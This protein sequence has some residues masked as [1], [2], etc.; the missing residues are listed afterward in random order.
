MDAAC[1]VPAVA[2][3]P[4]EPADIR[5]G[6]GRAPRG[7][8]GREPVDPDRRETPCS[9]CWASA[10]A[11]AV[12]AACPDATQVAGRFHLWKNLCEAVEKCVGEHRKYLAEP[13][14]DTTADKRSSDA[15]ATP[16]CMPSTTRACRSS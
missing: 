15:S 12:R 10:Y 6:P 5:A 8:A 16:R 2:A 13:S 14:E 3:R 11:E 1:S 7:P 4:G 9:G